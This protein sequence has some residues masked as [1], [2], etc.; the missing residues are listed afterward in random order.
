MI[1]KMLNYYDS[2]K[3]NITLINTSKLVSGTMIAQA[4][5]LLATPFIS[6]TYSPTNY[7]EFAL[8]SALCNII[9]GFLGFG[10]MSAIITAEKYEDAKGIYQFTNISAIVILIILYTVTISL[11]PY[12]HFFDLGSDYL[13]T[14]FLIFIYL[15]VVNQSNMLYALINRQGKFNILMLNPIIT[16][17]FNVSIVLILGFLNYKNYGL[18]LGTVLSQIINLI[19]M[20]KNCGDTKYKF[21][22]EKSIKL[23][24]KYKDF[25]LFQYP[26][27]IFNMFAN[28]LPSLLI[29]TFFGSIVLGYYSMCQR[30]LGMPVGTIGVAAGRVFIK[31]ASEK[32]NSGNPMGNYVLEHIR[33]TMNVASL[34]LIALIGFGD[35]LFPFVLGHQWNIAGIYSRILA[36]W[37]VFMFIV[38]CTSGLPAILR[39]QKQNLFFGIISFLV[40]ILAIFIGGF[41]FKSDILLIFLLTI[42]NVIVQI[43]FFSILFKATEL[44]IAEFVIYIIKY[45]FGIITIALLLRLLF[46]IC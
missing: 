37:Y 2:I 6:R 17:G 44:K 1:K 42:F 18:I 33:T 4:I 35:I 46:N 40:N 23:I 36:V 3:N 9:L 45:I 39:Y 20:Y 22:K 28:Q 11:S 31:E 41:V 19:H 29:S 38:N 8:F 27:G 43:I 13:L 15:I 12:V 10:L 7:G 26:S 30:V 16:S 25:I 5:T 21:T 32:Y 34:P 24:K 14:I